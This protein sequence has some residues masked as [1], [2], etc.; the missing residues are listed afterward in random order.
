MLASDDLLPRDDI[1]A[2]QDVMSYQ[3][4]LADC[5]LDQPVA[6][7]DIGGMRWSRRSALLLAIRWLEQGMSAKAVL[8]RVETLGSLHEERERPAG[9]ILIADDDP[10][11][12]L[13]ISDALQTVSYDVI[14]AS[15]GLEAIE[16]VR[17]D[18]PHLV[19]MD[20]SM[21]VLDGPSAIRAIRADP[22]IA[23][24]RIIAMS[25]GSNLWRVVEELESDSIIGKPFDIDVLIAD[26]RL[27][28]R[29]AGAR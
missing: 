26:V 20:L 11:I 21:P 16:V 14:T 10:T 15:N 12:R 22:E 4:R 28:L 7:V 18:R 24:T 23:H 5:I 3:H 29:H 13:L 9:T 8:R 2:S 25:I 6:A 1:D 19:L 27:H 17:R